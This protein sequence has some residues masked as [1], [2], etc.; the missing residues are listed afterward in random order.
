[1]QN[2]SFSDYA[3]PH[4]YCDNVLQQRLS[5]ERASELHLHT[6]LLRTEHI[7]TRYRMYVQRRRKL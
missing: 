6:S 4:R 5:D 7:C 3:E 2:A 1:M